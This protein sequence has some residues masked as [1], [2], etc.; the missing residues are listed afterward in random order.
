MRSGNKHKSC[1]HAD[2]KNEVRTPGPQQ[3]ETV[4]KG[5][6]SK[7]CGHADLFSLPCLS[8]EIYV[9]LYT[10]LYRG[11]GSK[12][13]RKVRKVRRHYKTRGLRPADLI[14]RCPQRSA[15]EDPRTN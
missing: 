11:R 9:S 6:W 1:G 5:V 8:I 14:F 15:N 12:Q 13:V 7:Y 4:K 2:F 10:S 3:F